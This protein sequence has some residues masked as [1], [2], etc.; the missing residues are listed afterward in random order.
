[1]VATQIARSRF[2]DLEGGRRHLL[3]WGEPGAPVVVLLHGM[4]DHAHSWSWV[5]QSLA[6]RYRIIAPDL[7]GHGD[8]DWSRDRDYTLPSYVRDLAEIVEASGLADIN[9]VGHSLGGQIALRFAASFPERI[10]SQ[11][12][13]EGVELP[14]IRQE[15]QEPTPY[16]KRVRD[17]L[18]HSR[19]RREWKPRFYSTIALAERRMRE[20]HPNI[21]QATLAFLTRTGI[22]EEPG[23]GWRWK[24]DDACRYR[25][26]EDQRGQDLDELLEAITSPSILAYGDESWISPPPDSRLAH[27]REHRVVRFANASHWLHHQRREQFCALLDRFFP[28]PS[29]FLKSERLLH[30]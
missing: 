23:K 13:I 16:P 10:R 26:P 29:D 28:E 27:L 21:D 24:Y 11:V 8:S 15:R 22:T 30:A 3:E 20:A 4:R 2:I 5:A 17:W 14:L 12:L 18:E 7:R 6:D 19:S 1:M 9:I 25:P